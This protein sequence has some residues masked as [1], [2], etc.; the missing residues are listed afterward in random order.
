MENTELF[1]QEGRLC[2]T[3]VVR[4]KEE[5]KKKEVW[6]ELPVVTVP[7]NT[8]KNIK[9][10]SDSVAPLLLGKFPLSCGWRFL[11]RSFLC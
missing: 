6:D 11:F 8:L 2:I 9:Q 5:K 4:S 3:S 10:P 7:S 1:E